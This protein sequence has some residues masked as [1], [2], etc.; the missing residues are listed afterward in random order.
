MES[1]RE[2]RRFMTVNY[3]KCLLLCGWFVSGI[4]NASPPTTRPTEGLRDKTPGVHALRGARVFVAPGQVIDAAT[5]V[6]RDGI[7]VSVRKDGPVPAEA[8]EWDASGQTIYPGLID[9]FSEVSIDP[10]TTPRGAAHSNGLVTPQWQGAR[11]CEGPRQR[12]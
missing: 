9:S 11:T 4:A 12:E 6:I 1:R 3:G 10:S 2:R 7:I 8:R 5:I